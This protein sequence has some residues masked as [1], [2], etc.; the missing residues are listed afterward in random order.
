MWTFGRIGSPGERPCPCLVEVD[1]AED[2]T[3][4][5]QNSED[6]ESTLEPAGSVAQ[7]HG[8]EDCLVLFMD[9]PFALGGCP[10]LRQVL[11]VCWLA[12]F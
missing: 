8:V 6:P 11:A 1:Q 2:G 7:A 4:E 12:R 5:H 10:H 9:E 3:D